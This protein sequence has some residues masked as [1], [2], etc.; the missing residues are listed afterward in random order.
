MCYVIQQS[1]LRHLGSTRQPWGTCR[2]SDSSVSSYRWAR[3]VQDSGI[4]GIHN[5]SRMLLVMSWSERRVRSYVKKRSRL[6][7]H[8]RKQS[9]FCS[10]KEFRQTDYVKQTL[11]ASANTYLCSLTRKILLQGAPCGLNLVAA[12]LCIGPNL[13]QSYFFWRA[14][15][16]CEKE[17]WSNAT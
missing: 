6:E 12:T 5:Q 11:Y 1:N 17:K 15:F 10:S 9:N 2:C 4:E 16:F 7:Y 3:K 14:V 13:R 8:Y